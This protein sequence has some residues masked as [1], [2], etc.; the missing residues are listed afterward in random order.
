[1]DRETILGYVTGFLDAASPSFAGDTLT[2]KFN[3]AKPLKRIQGLFGGTLEREQNL[4]IYHLNGIKVQELKLEARERSMVR[5]SR[6]KD[7][8]LAGVLEA[9]GVFCVESFPDGFCE[10]ALG[11][12]IGIDVSALPFIKKEFGGTILKG[13][14]LSW[15]SQGAEASSNATTAKRYMTF[16]HEEAELLRLFN[17]TSKHWRERRA[18]GIATPP[19]I[20]NKQERWRQR[21]LELE[22][23]RAETN[24][25]RS[26][27]VL[28]SDGPSYG[29]PQ[30]VGF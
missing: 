6:A 21:L 12:L 26:E 14:K 23:A 3:Q 25:E 4:V 19:R 22:A 29:A 5:K 10:P 28:M 2:V 9:C 13:H 18:T 20:L 30:A 11:L 17:T 7:A 16:R 1:M 8:Y 15:L 27:S 24:P